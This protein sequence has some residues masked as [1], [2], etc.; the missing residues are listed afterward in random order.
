MTEQE[1]FEGTSIH[2]LDL[3]GAPFVEDYREPLEFPSY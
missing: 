1:D 2:A 3:A